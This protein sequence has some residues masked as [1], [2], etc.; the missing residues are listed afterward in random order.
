MED[1]CTSVSSSLLSSFTM[2]HSDQGF[3]ADDIVKTGMLSTSSPSY[4]SI[5]SEICNF[6]SDEGSDTETFYVEDS[7]PFLDSETRTYSSSSESHTLGSF[8]SRKTKLYFSMLSRLGNSRLFTNVSKTKARFAPQSIIN[9]SSLDRLT[10]SKYKTNQFKIDSAL[11][12]LH[13]P[14]GQEAIAVEKQDRV[15]N[16]ESLLRRRILYPVY[17]YPPAI[18][19]SHIITKITEGTKQQRK[20]KEKQDLIEIYNLPVDVPVLTPNQIKNLEMNVAKLF[21]HIQWG[22]PCGINHLQVL[23]SPL[24]H[25]RKKLLTDMIIA[26]VDT[27]VLRMDQISHLEFTLRQNILY[28]QM[29]HKMMPFE[30]QVP[31][32]N[33]CPME[34]NI[35]QRDV[36]IISED[37][38]NDLEICLEKMVLQHNCTPVIPQKSRAT[39]GPLSSL[40]PPLKTYVQRRI[41]PTYPKHGFTHPLRTL[42]STKKYKYSPSRCTFSPVIRKASNEAMTPKLHFNTIK[43]CHEEFQTKYQLECHLSR[44]VIEIKINFAP[45][46]VKTSNDKARLAQRKKSL[47]IFGQKDKRFRKARCEQILYMEQ[48]TINQINLNIKQKHLQFLWGITNIYR[49]SLAKLVPKSSQLCTR[50][51]SA[52]SKEVTDMD[53]PFIPQKIRDVLELHIAHKELEHL[54]NLPLQ[55]KKSLNAIMPVPLKLFR[56]KNRVQQKIVVANLLSQIIFLNERNIQNLEIHIKKIKIQK[57][58]R[59]PTKVAEYLNQFALLAPSTQ[60]EL[61][62]AGEERI[63]QSGMICRNREHCQVDFLT[64]GTRVQADTKPFCSRCFKNSSKPQLQICEDDEIHLHFILKSLDVQMATLP[65]LVT[66]S[67][68]VAYLMKKEMIP[69]LIGPGKN[70]L[71]V[72]SIFF[73]FMES[74]VI[75][76]L[77][78]NIKHKYIGFLWE[79]PSFYRKSSE[80]TIPKRPSFPQLKASASAT[81]VTDID[82]SFMP[83]Y[84]RKLLEWHVQKKILQLE[85]G[86]PA[87]ASTSLTAFMS[88][89]P[90]IIKQNYNIY[91]QVAVT[92]LISQLRFISGKTCCLFESHIKKM[93][94]ERKRGLPPK[95]EKSL[96]R[97][98]PRVPSVQKQRAPSESVK[99]PIMILQQDEVKRLSQASRLQNGTQFQAVEPPAIAHSG[100]TKA[101]E[102]PIIPKSGGDKNE[103]YMHFTKKFLE[104]ISGTIPK[105]ADQSYKRKHPYR[106]RNLPKIIHSENLVPKKKTTG[107]LFMQPHFVNNLNMN[108]LHKY[109]DFL[110]GLP[111]IY[112]E[113]LRKI[114]PVVPSMCPIM[115]SPGKMSE[116]IDAETPFMPEAVGSNSEWQLQMTKCKEHLEWNI[117]AKELEKQWGFPVKIQE[118][119]NSFMPSVP[120]VKSKDSL[121]SPTQVLFNISDPPF[122]RREAKQNL[123]A[124]QKKAILLKKMK[125]PKRVQDS[126][127]TFMP[128]PPTNDV[129][130]HTETDREL[131]TRPLFYKVKDKAL[132]DL[133]KNMK[134]TDL[135][136][137]SEQTSVCKFYLKAPGEK[138]KLEKYL[139]IKSLEI[140]TEATPSLVQCSNKSVYSGKKYKFPKLFN[141]GERSKRARITFLPFIEQ[142]PLDRISLNL[143]HK[144]LLFLW[145]LP[146]AYVSS[147]QKLTPLVPLQ[148]S[149]NSTAETP[150]ESAE[151]Q[152][153]FVSRHILENLEYCI[154]C[155]TL[156]HCWGTPLEVQQSLDELIPSVPKFQTVKQLLKAYVRVMPIV[157]DLPF[158]DSDTKKNLEKDIKRIIEQHSLQQ[159]PRALEPPSPS[160]NDVQPELSD[161]GKKN[162]SVASENNQETML[163]PE[164]PGVTPGTSEATFKESKTDEEKTVAQLG[165]TERDPPSDFK[166]LKSAMKVRHQE[167]PP[168]NPLPDINDKAEIKAAIEFHL[169]QKADYSGCMKVPLHVTDSVKLSKPP[170]VP[171]FP[172][173]FIDKS[174]VLYSALEPRE[175]L[176]NKFK[177]RFTLNFH[178]R[179]KQLEEN[180]GIPPTVQKSRSLAGK[181]APAEAGQGIRRTVS[182][183]VYSQ[184]RRMKDDR[185]TSH[186]VKHVELYAIDNRPF[187]K[188]HITDLLEFNF[189]KMKF[190]QQLGSNSLKRSVSS[191]VSENAD[192]SLSPCR[193]KPCSSEHQ[194]PSTSTQLPSV[195]RHWIVS[196]KDSSVC[197]L[198]RSHYFHNTESTIK[199]SKTPQ[200]KKHPEMEAYGARFQEGSKISSMFSRKLDTSQIKKSSSVTK[201]SIPGQGEN[202]KNLLNIH[203]M[204][205]IVMNSS[206]LPACV[207]EANNKY[208]ARQIQ[209]KRDAARKLRE[210]LKHNLQKLRWDAEEKQSYIFDFVNKQ[211]ILP[212]EDKLEVTEAPNSFRTEVNVYFPHGQ[213]SFCN[214]YHSFGKKEEEQS[215]ASS[216]FQNEIF[217]KAIFN[218]PSQK[219]TPSSEESEVSENDKFQDTT[220]CQ[221]SSDS[222][223]LLPTATASFHD[224]SH[225]MEKLNKGAYN[226]KNEEIDTEFKVPLKMKVHHG[227]HK[228]RSHKLTHSDHVRFGPTIYFPHISKSHSTEFPES[229]AEHDGREAKN[230][231]KNENR[232][233]STTTDQ[234]QGRN[235]NVSRQ[236]EQTVNDAPNGKA[237]KV[238]QGIQ[239]SDHA[240]QKHLESSTNPE[241]YS[242]F[243]GASRN[244]NHDRPPQRPYYLRCVQ[245]PASTS[246]KHIWQRLPEMEG[247]KSEADTLRKGGCSKKTFWNSI[248][249]LY[250][251]PITFKAIKD[252]FHKLGL[253]QK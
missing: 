37:N 218:A 16:L 103:L 34:V 211:K 72:R 221:R 194:H 205:K 31:Q 17:G 29:Y 88:P 230:I 204:Q 3:S 187:N 139:V 18:V 104:I 133:L 146:S 42:E 15:Q 36:P 81:E 163:P 243:K 173:S 232:N 59:V 77:D 30:L 229:P 159:S 172:S 191:D 150:T 11:Y 143:K 224:L 58:C 97:F 101:M 207:I 236:P 117:K 242:S 71:R 108:I 228:S 186:R 128:L 110:W 237:L 32:K 119:L 109:L 63:S 200:I 248:K 215:S 135:E 52:I 91:P 171:L 57:K 100:V 197:H 53:V 5:L 203:L 94:T 131:R 201:S 182:E 252:C 39:F 24:S 154:K 174:K 247:L 233:Y 138:D 50:T 118:S 147:T 47:P 6:M 112:T 68:K 125:L 220:H 73:P 202:K 41:C 25:K 1:K 67:Y 54:L 141:P 123:E 129:V 44:K 180:F 183:D 176:R 188:K 132:L 19:E 167:K 38:I 51:S 102:R 156:E 80:K 137:R 98:L 253:H 62:Q 90:Q 124:H 12:Y 20:F 127:S 83:R 210:K 249:E 115:K 189:K 155:K 113:S 136:A 40:L 65:A 126:L 195:P 9:S 21:L 238:D 28:H 206:I 14:S 111:S 140:K 116:L 2:I 216:N 27:P 75:S 231:S 99:H 217:T 192:P 199:Y 178:L 148:C 84:V 74:Y 69:K 160:L 223:H 61:T 235:N 86:L 179:K 142:E 56:P 213:I 166:T 244:G 175:I 79:L 7:V 145:K 169:K 60:Q 92:I 212:T 43:I 152:T 177:E 35:M 122:I 250:T 161:N 49:V 219:Q 96:P 4:S 120:A 95:V 13:S 214:F 225:L 23:K 107:L 196:V 33:I 151:E 134:E 165:Q 245:L 48:K 10:S 162:E 198:P 89:A 64:L 85:W 164:S 241:D 208:K 87:T 158:L 130:S 106:K 70:T 78:M 168:N 209:E 8:T 144:Y 26:V 105:V 45:K 121:H 55:L 184:C 170:P 76:V 190:N 93:I 66:K 46:Y 22:S 246:D 153:A 193:D 234:S 114:I 227:A 82:T 240:F 157:N 149:I 226:E 251:C 181:I 222:S 185:R 239:T